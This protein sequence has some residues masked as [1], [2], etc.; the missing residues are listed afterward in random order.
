[1]AVSLWKD[2]GEH[3]CGFEES[4]DDSRVSVSQRNPYSITCATKTSV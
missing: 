3:D 1:M 4:I 2:F